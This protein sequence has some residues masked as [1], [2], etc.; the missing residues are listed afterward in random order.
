MDDRA[1]AAL[2]VFAVVS[3]ASLVLLYLIAPFLGRKTPGSGLVAAGLVLAFVALW[4]GLLTGL[5][6]REHVAVPYGNPALADGLLKLAT[7]LVLGSIVVSLLTRDA[8]A[9]LSPTPERPRD[10]PPS[11]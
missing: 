9:P 8:T 11:V 7:V 10:V 3:L 6:I 5:P 1:V 2:G 4:Y